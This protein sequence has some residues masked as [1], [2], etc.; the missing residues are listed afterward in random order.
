MPDQSTSETLLRRLQQPADERAWDRFVE[1]YT[2]LLCYWAS[3]SGF[4]EA[5]RAD[6]VQEVLLLLVQKLPEFHYDQKGSFRCWLRTVAL[7]CWR[8]HHR[9]DRSALPTEPTDLDAIAVPDGV[10]QFWREEYLQQLTRR[11]LVLMQRDFEEKTW[12]ACWGCVVEGKSASA[13]AQELGLSVGAVHVA[14]S[15]VVSRL[16]QELGDMLD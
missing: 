5:D 11:A 2:P 6:L 7:N 15:R 12:K 4:P 1:L 16:R 13:V 9:R 14:K 8:N 3:R 10:E